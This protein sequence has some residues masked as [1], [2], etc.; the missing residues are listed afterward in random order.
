MTWARNRF[1]HLPIL[2][3]GLPGRIQ[4]QMMLKSVVTLSIIFWEAQVPVYSCYAQW[5]VP[6]RPQYLCPGERLLPA[7]AP[8][9]CF[10][11]P[12][13]WILSRSQGAP[14]EIAFN[15]IPVVSSQFALFILNL[16]L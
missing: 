2:T 3:D 15:D 8:T 12:G 4:K 1:L 14:G 5:P 16:G 13:T 6:S 7:P 11:M 9:P 10:P